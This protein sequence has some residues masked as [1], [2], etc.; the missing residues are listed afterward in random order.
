M[1][2]PFLN[3][4]FDQIRKTAVKVCVSFFLETGPYQ[5]LRQAADGLEC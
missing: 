3:G 5:C 4:L 1:V 2:E